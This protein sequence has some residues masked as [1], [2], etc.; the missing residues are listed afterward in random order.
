MRSFKRIKLYLK[1]IWYHAVFWSFPTLEETYYSQL[2]TV[3]FYLHKYRKSISLYEKSEKSHNNQDGSY[4]KYNSIYLGYSYLNLG[5]F[6]K[7]FEW[8]EINRKYDKKNLEILAHLGWCYALT[9]QPQEALRIY[10]VGAELE[11]ENPRWHAESAKVLIELKQND[12]ALKQIELAK[13][14]AKDSID[15]GLVEI[16]EHKLNRNNQGAIDTSMKVISE[17]K[18]NSSH[19][20]VADLYMSISE[21]QK[22]IGDKEGALTTLETALKDIPYDAWIK[23]HLAMEYADREIKLDLALRVIEE[24]IE[25]QPDNSLFID[26]KGWVLYK[27]GK[28][29]EARKEI[30]KSLKLNPDYKDTL[31]HYELI[32]T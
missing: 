31:E 15:K 13:P 8:F 27:M 21:W 14:K 20:D 12:E 5:D 6:V 1:L 28:K 16:I 4:T 10:S 11:P 17:L 18:N 9:N 24:A 30:E 7:A 29:E 19:A 23:N 32:K 26:T 3:Y 25:Y 22:E 2:A